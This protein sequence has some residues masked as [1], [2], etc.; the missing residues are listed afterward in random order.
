MPLWSFRMLRR[1][2]PLLV[3][4]LMATQ[5]D[6]AEVAPLPPASAV[7]KVCK[8]GLE[9]QCDALFTLASG[10]LPENGRAELANGRLKTAW[11]Y[12]RNKMEPEGERAVVH[13]AQ[14]FEQIEVPKEFTGKSADRLRE[15]LV[16]VKASRDSS[17]LTP[18]AFVKAVD[19]LYGAPK[20]KL[21]LDQ[22]PPPPPPQPPVVVT[23]PIQETGPE[24]PELPPR[25]DVPARDAQAWQGLVAGGASAVALIVGVVAGID[26][27]N[28]HEAER[29]ASQAGDF[30]TYQAR[31]QQAQRASLA[32]D[33][34]CIAAVA[35]G[36]GTFI[37]F[38]DAGKGYFNN[39]GKASVVVTPAARP[40]QAS[41]V[42]NGSF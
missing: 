24:G 12:I 9:E 28:N 5:V 19:A 30:P 10:G 34:S 14:L 37:F 13:A 42:V 8:A 33:L 27:S 35:G 23:P 2:L 31:Q 20:D 26:W 15:I 4:A 39:A 6:G 11:Q 7:S 3:A 22:Q 29:L 32:A 40:G 17:G 1:R 25:K 38:S 41:I 36:L 21:N 18:T 16:K